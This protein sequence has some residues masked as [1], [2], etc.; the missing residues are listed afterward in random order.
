MAREKPR[1]GSPPIGQRLVAAACLI[2]ALPAAA[3]QTSFYPS[4]SLEAGHTDNLAFVGE[5]NEATSTNLMR[6]LADL[7]WT[8]RFTRS[9][10]DLTYRPALYRY[11][12]AHALDRD[13][14]RLRV[15]YDRLVEHR[16]SLSV[17]S[18]FSLTQL[19]GLAIEQGDPD[20]T[21]TERTDRKYGSVRVDFS[22]QV[23]RNWSWI[24]G[25]NVARHAFDQIGSTGV[26]SSSVED[27][28]E[29]G[30]ATGMSKRLSRRT[31]T[32]F[33]L[34]GAIYDLET[35]GRETVTRIDWNL[36]KE[37]GRRVDL[38]LNV[39]IFRRDRSDSE[40]VSGSEGDTVG[41]ILRL[42]LNA[43]FRSA[44]LRFELRHQP[45]D[46]GARLGTSTNTSAYLN[47]S[48]TGSGALGWG[49]GLRYSLRDPSDGVSKI[50]TLS[51]GGNLEWGFTSSW[52]LRFGG[53]YAEQ[54]GD[55]S[56]DDGSYLAV[57]LG[58]AWY[59]KGR[60]RPARVRGG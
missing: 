1:R 3:K 32:A 13:E 54:K 44:A 58:V 55:D 4:L 50:E 48:S 52:G 12:D 29:F 10:L 45:T 20:P 6:L 36:D 31:T 40:P 35:S 16:S 25:S 43:D 47:Y 33:T 17:R 9:D 7:P 34:G 42:R 39:G 28:T 41:G 11:P 21:L 2:V 27:R 51:L 19:Q 46:G 56:F 30:V 5:P 14:H 15:D 8:W 59:P 26:G 38:N 22:K 53:N 18:T 23:S 57:S 60:E 24:L 49:S 37:V